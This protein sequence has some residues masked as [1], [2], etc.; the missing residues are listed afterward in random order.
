M[1]NIK[2][3]YYKFFGGWKYTIGFPQATLQE[4]MEGK[5]MKIKWLAENPTSSWFADPFI[6]DVTDEEYVVLVEE[7]L[8]KKK[9]G[10]ISLLIIDKETCKIKKHAIVLEEDTHLSFPNILRINGDIYIYPENCASLLLNLYKYD[11]SRKSFARVKK[12][13][14]GDFADSVMVE[15]FGKKWLFTTKGTDFCPSELRIMKEGGNSKMFEEFTTIVFPKKIARGAG[16]FFYYN[17]E[18]YRPAQECDVC[19]G[20]SVSIQKVYGSSMQDIKFKEVLQLYSDNPNYELGLHTFNVYKGVIVVDAMGYKHKVA[21][22]F[23]KIV[24]KCFGER[25]R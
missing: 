18:L 24:K 13:A 7:M 11:S 1:N 12:I 16:S 4:I 8:L 3:L 22:L 15:L 19:Y 10:V 23:G 25:I 6:L 14:E 21:R 5:P 9:K 2:Q 17:G 20:H